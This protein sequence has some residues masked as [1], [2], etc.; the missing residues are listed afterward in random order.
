MT[1]RPTD[2]AIHA[3][4][5]AADGGDIHDKGARD[6]GPDRDPDRE[7]GLVDLLLVLAENARLLVI[8]PLVAALVALAVGSLLP[9]RWESVTLLRGASPTLV[10]VLTAPAV[11]PP[12][13]PAAPRPTRLEVSIP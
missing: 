9:Q 3:L 13:A 8:G 7:L 11:L 10:T 12:A 1:A 4:A 6:S 2:P 5:I